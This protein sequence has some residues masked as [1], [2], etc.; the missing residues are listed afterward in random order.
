M[1]NNIDIQAL[2]T[3]EELYN[4]NN[5]IF[6]K[7]LNK[8]KKGNLLDFGCGFGGFIKHCKTNNLDVIGFEINNVAI[9]KLQDDNL[10][11]ELDKNNLE[12]KYE[13]LV[14]IN[15]LEH[16]ENDNEAIKEFKKILK[17][18]GRLILYLPH[19][20]YLWTE[21]D[22]LVGHHRRYTK[23]NLVTKLKE[24]GFEIKHVEYVD[25]VGSIVLSVTKFLRIKLSYNKNLT[26]FYDKTVFKTFKYLDYIFKNIFGKNILIVADVTK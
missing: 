5:Y 25:F 26:I 23:K 2:E 22:E 3:T 18:N 20:K 15:V 6:S 19:S 9:K 13:N 16:I 11:I 21:L 4:Y 1:N 24:N 14:S 8:I 10:Q 7:I 17:N 12:N